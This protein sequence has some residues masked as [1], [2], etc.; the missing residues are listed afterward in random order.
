MTTD[1]RHT[2]LHMHFPL[3]TSHA[4][5]FSNSPT[6]SHLSICTPGAVMY[7]DDAEPSSAQLIAHSHYPL[8]TTS[9][10]VS[11]SSMVSP[12]STFHIQDDL[13][14]GEL[15]A[16]AVTATAALAAAACWG[17]GCHTDASGSCCGCCWF[18]LII[19][20]GGNAA[21]NLLVSLSPKPGAAVLPH[22]GAGHMTV[23]GAGIGAGLLPPP[24]TSSGCSAVHSRTI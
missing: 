24:Q 14:G 16:T 23:R 18:C 6:T 3:P 12:G 19:G 2:T 11:V 20:C 8:P 1:N 22:R 7:N 4:V 9:T 10:M 13:V 15:A 5:S 17:V 21:D